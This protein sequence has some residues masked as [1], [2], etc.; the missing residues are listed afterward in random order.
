MTSA[1]FPPVPCEPELLAGAESVR[2]EGE[3][4]T[5]FGEES[6]AKA[7]TRRRDQ[8][9]FLRRATDA[10]EDARTNGSGI[11]ADQFLREMCERAETARMRI[12]ADVESR[13]TASQQAS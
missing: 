10:I 13:K 12:I 8:D 9:A 7:V 5:D 1:D 2:A 3:T 11:P 4:P 6:V